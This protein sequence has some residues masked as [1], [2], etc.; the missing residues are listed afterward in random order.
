L[1]C[2]E[3]YYINKDIEDL[4]VIS[5]PHKHEFQPDSST[6][7]A[8]FN[9]FKVFVG[10]GI[11][12]MPGAFSETGL[13]L[14]CIG[15]L[16]IAIANT[17]TMAL[18]CKLSD[19][20]GT[21]VTS[22]SELGLVIFG[23]RCK[24]FIDLS[25]WVSQV[26][27]CISYIMFIAK[28]I[29]HIICVETGNCHNRGWFILGLVAILIPL[30][31]TRKFKSLAYASFLANI[32]IIFSLGVILWYGGAA[33][34]SNDHRQVKQFDFPRIPLFFGVAVFCFEGNAIVLNVK[35]S[36]K[37]PKKFESVLIW[38]MVV[39]CALVMTV[40]GLSYYA[41]GANT[42]DIITLNL[43]ENTLTSIT[44]GLY[45]FG[46]LCS[47]QIQLVPAISIFEKTQFFQNLTSKFWIN[48]RFY[49]FRSLIV[50]ITGGIAVLIPNFGLFIN[51]SGAF[52]S[53]ALAFV[54]PPL[55]YLKYF[56]DQITPLSKIANYTSLAIGIIGG[57]IS[58][59]M[60]LLALF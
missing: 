36:M 6:S 38:T 48:F 21:K 29:D 11:L 55:L 13:A 31:W 54:L 30:S 14:G 5:D 9:M 12:A 47:Y 16:V 27:L 51:L 2:D 24:S 40:A 53:A 22:Y 58:I 45:A 26:G 17:Y 10:I 42:Q 23:N 60:T 28:G 52:S 59:V 50:I 7:H 41:Y 57:L 44:Q 32:A 20:L 43:P 8:Y 37:E 1:I 46:L 56:K 34:E 18:L 3:S 15:L 19:A 25:I 33:V 4:S 35:A 39:V 49:L